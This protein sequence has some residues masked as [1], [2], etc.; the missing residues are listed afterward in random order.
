MPAEVARVDGGVAVVVDGEPVV[1]MESHDQAAPLLAWVDYQ[2]KEG[3][4]PDEIR[5]LLRGESLSAAEADLSVLE[6]SIG[7]LRK[8][9][10]SGDHD[11]HL[12]ALLAAERDGKARKG[13]LEALESRQEG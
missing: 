1:V 6:G 7:A 2:L 10:A 3:K 12:D 9:L 13:A 5:T 4:S 11:E 8:A